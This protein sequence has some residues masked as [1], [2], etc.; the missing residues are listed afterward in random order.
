MDTPDIQ[1]MGL[2]AVEWNEDY[3]EIRAVNAVEPICFAVSA[4]RPLLEMMTVIQ[5]AQR[6]YGKEKFS[7]RLT[8]YRIAEINE[9]FGLVK[10]VRPRKT[11]SWIV[12]LTYF[13]PSGKYYADGEYTSR[14]ESMFQILYETRNMILRGER[15]GLCEESS[16]YHVL[17]D[18]PS[19]PNNCPSLIPLEVDNA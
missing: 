11:F 7:L 19:H 3:D 15:P 17:V 6:A 18:V 8:A 12:K 5:R 14:R 16:K 2:P 9:A 4:D 13:K 10:P 1:F